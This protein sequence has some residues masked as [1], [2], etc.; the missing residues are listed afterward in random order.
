MVQ[1]SKGVYRERLDGDVV[2]T[3]SQVA[4]PALPTGDSDIVAMTGV[5]DPALGP[6]L[7]TQPDASHGGK[8]LQTVAGT[9][10]PQTSPRVHTTGRARVKE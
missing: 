5:T 6:P 9:L 2:C 1:K 3:G 8:S 7:A 4:G 10:D